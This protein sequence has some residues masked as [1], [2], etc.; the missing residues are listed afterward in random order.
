MEFGSTYESLRGRSFNALLNNLE[1]IH[2]LAP[3]GINYV[4][5]KRT[6]PELDEAIN[7]ATEVGAKEFLLLPEHPVKGKGGIDFQTLKQFQYWVYKYKGPIPL[8]TSEVPAIGLPICN[9]TNSETGLLAYAHIDAE[10]I[11]KRTS[12]DK[13]GVSIGTGGVIPALKVLLADLEGKNENLEQLRL[14]A[15]CK[16][17]DDRTLSRNYEM[18][19]RQNK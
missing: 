5:N 8:T 9:P 14:R 10:G 7:I 11:L 2:N 12:Y 13:G 17:S 4:I 16:P 18:S 3:F 19:T 1:A 15:F 6:L